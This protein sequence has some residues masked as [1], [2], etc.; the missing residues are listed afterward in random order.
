MIIIIIYIT[1]IPIIIII[2]NIIIIAIFIIVTR[3]RYNWFLIQTYCKRVL[4]QNREYGKRGKVRERKWNW[5][6]LFVGFSETNG[7]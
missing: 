4:C 3:K 6:Q 7:S 5:E 1:V 2:N